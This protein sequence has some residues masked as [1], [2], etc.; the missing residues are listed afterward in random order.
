M[1]GTVI[2]FVILLGY[3]SLSSETIFIPHDYAT[4]QDGIDAS[5]SGDLI[6]VDP[7]VYVENIDFNWKGITLASLYYSTQDTSYISQT[8][9]DGNHSGCVATIFCYSNQEAEFC[10]FTIRNGFGEYGGGI[11]CFGSDNFYLHHLVIEDNENED[12]GGLTIGDCS[13]LLTDSIIKNNTAVNGGGIQIW[14]GNVELQNVIIKDNYADSYGGGINCRSS[15]LT[16]SLVTITGNR[17][18][19]RGGGISFLHENTVSLDPVQRCNIYDNFLTEHNIGN[20]IYSM[21]EVEVI[22]DMFSIRNPSEFHVH[23]LAN[24]TFDILQGYHQQLEGD[25][26]VSPLGDNGNSGISPE[27]PLKTIR[28]ACSVFYAGSSNPG[29]LHLMNGIYSPSTNGEYYPVSLPNYVSLIGESESSVILDAEEQNCV[30]DFFDIDDENYEAHLSGLTITNGAVLAPAWGG[31]GIYCDSPVNVWLEN[32]SII[33]NY[34]FRCGAGIFCREGEMYLSNVSI[35]DNTA[36]YEGGGIYGGNAIFIIDNTVIRDNQS[37]DPERGFGGGIYS[38]NCEFTISETQILDNIAE[39]GGGGINSQENSNLV[40]ENVIFDNNHSENNG[41]GLYSFDDALI[42]AY[43]VTFRDNSSSSFGGG[44]YCDRTELEIE[45]N[46]FSGNSAY[47]GAGIYCYMCYAD[48]RK[49]IIENNIA[50]YTGGGIYTMNNASTW[51]ENVTCTSNTAGFNGGGIFGMINSFNSIYNSIM[52]NNSPQEIYYYRIGVYNQ[53]RVAYSDIAG[54]I[55]AVELNENGN[56]QQWEDN[57]DIDP[58]FS[59]ANGADYS[60]QSVSPCIDAGTSYLEYCGNIVINL[61]EDEFFG[62]APD[63]GACEFN[64][65]NCGDVDASREIDSFDAAAVLMYATGLDPLPEDPYPW[66][67]WRLILADVDLNG[68]IT[69]FDA[70]CILHYVVGIIDE[71]PVMERDILPAGGITLSQDSSYIYINSQNELISLFCEIKS[72]TDLKIA[73]AEILTEDCLFYQ[74]GNRFAFA[75]ARAVSG[76]L[77]KIPYQAGFLEDKSIILHIEDNGYKYDLEYDL[78]KPSEIMSVFPNPFNPETRITF[79]HPETGNISL[80]VYNLKGQQV[81]ELVNGNL[82]KGEHSVVWNGQ[83]DDGKAVS[84]GLYLL[85]FSNGSKHSF[86]KIML[87]K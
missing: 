50:Q 10:G 65:F 27:S 87:M 14:G 66:S 59:D 23:P 18:E 30:V 73:K 22:V 40:M 11:A 46:L 5:E 49:T 54:G 1:K 31:A 57:L 55:S 58:L 15:E 43:D 39:M 64:S 86:R 28:Y 69:A 37:L 35:T 56:I 45:N 38:S 74:Q 41:G 24:F 77:V 9:I 85:K 83:N 63:M 4:I 8:V 75:C 62:N 12:G 42:Q 76:K 67:D 72:E 32:I 3:F 29:V 21:V 80:I 82:V 16:M 61:D 47:S 51:M 19:Y 44:I 25:V 36:E 2:I 7:G 79:Q 6:L 68:E 81:K 60:L 26:Y 13:I 48:I 34:S 20:D 17:S 71:L 70:A 78:G 84:S 33:D 52:W 53:L